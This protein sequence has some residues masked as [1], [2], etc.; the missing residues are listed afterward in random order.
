[1]IRKKRYSLMAGLLSLFMVLAAIISPV[2][3]AQ[4]ASKATGNSHLTI[5][6]PRNGKDAEDDSPVRELRVYKLSDDNLTSEDLE[7]DRL[8]YDA[9]TTAEVEKKLET[10]GEVLKSTV[11]DSHDVIELKGLRPG[12]Y[13]LKETDESS[14]NH[15][16][17]VISSATNIQEGIIDAQEINVKVDQVKPLTLF[18]YTNGKKA[19]ETETIEE[20]EGGENSAQAEELEVAENPE[21]SDDTEN[22][23]NPELDEESERIE[24]I[25][26]AGVKFNLINSANDEVVELTKT[27]EGVYSYETTSEEVELVTDAKGYI[28]V[29]NLPTGNYYFKEVDTIEG[30]VIDN[31]NTEKFDYEKSKGQNI[32]KLN[33][34]ETKKVQVGLHKVDEE[35]KE[36]LAGVEFRL[37]LKSGNTL[38]PVGKNGDGVYDVG[39]EYQDTFKTDKEGKIVVEDLPKPADSA[40]YVFI[41]V[42]ALDDYYLNPDNYQIVK[43]NELVE[44]E[45][46]KNPTP[47]ELK[48]TKVDSFTNEPIDKVEFELLRVRVIDNDD[49]TK[50]IKEEKVVV[51]G[52]NGSY[53]FRDDIA[54][55]E[56]VHQLYTDSN[57]QIT[58]KNLPD[59]EYFFREKEPHKDY[60]LPENRGKES[61]RLKRNN[62]TYTMENRPIHPPSVTPPGSN[63]KKGSHNFVKVDDSKEQKRLAGAT[64]ALYK[65]NEKGEQIPYEV[66]GKRYTIKSGSNGEFK[67]EDLA[68]GKYVLRETAAPSGY[69]LNVNPIEFKISKDSTNA[70]AIMIV[71]KRNPERSVTP[72][73]TTTPPGTSTPPTTRTTVPPK[74]YYVPKDRPGIPKGPLVKTGDIRIIVFIAIG[75][76]MI[77]FGNHIVRKEEKIQVTSL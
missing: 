52:S 16:Y 23:E 20:V 32:E 56:E 26:L 37:Y 19:N 76:V 27:D 18:K 8:K 15:E 9:M 21:E 38:T 42:K 36:A 49:N 14:E 54:Q 12:A 3:N 39:N 66:D 4:E 7:S 28:T 44:I 17:R 53:E 75:L 58:V 60:D 69:I 30:Y 68:Y 67:V 48:L 47:H 46:Y 77:L 6:I 71:N 59:G 55:S 63:Y 61:E 11:E 1:M 33:R 43:N 73:G 25:G 70:E 13:L 41:E 62:T 22:S 72:P 24:K 51:A 50:T 57:G 31:P 35:T 2:S 74:T 65:V 40:E 64:F 45:N 29:N 34:K 10:V 5:K